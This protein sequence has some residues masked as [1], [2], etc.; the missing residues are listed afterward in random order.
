MGEFRFR[1]PDNWTLE[2]RQASSI[3]IVG[4]DGIPWPC[5]IFTEGNTLVVNRNHDESGRTYISYPFRDRGEFIICTGTLP[6]RPE[7]YDLLSE[8]ARGTLNRIRNQISVWEE[9]GFKVAANVHELTA[10]AT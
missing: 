4:I 3:H 2:T 9:G 1:L 6:E 5:R 8:L 7:Q 10:E